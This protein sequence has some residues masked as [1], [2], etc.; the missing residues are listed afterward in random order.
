MAKEK[1]ITEE[2][3]NTVKKSGPG[4]LILGAAALL[5]AGGAGAGSYFLTPAPVEKSAD[6]SEQAY[7]VNNADGADKHL[8]KSPKRKTKSH[9]AKESKHSKA[10]EAPNLGG[11]IQ[12]AGDTAFFVLDPLVV[13]INPIGRSRHLKVVLAVETAPEEADAIRQ[14]ALHIR[15]AYNTYL[16]SVDASIFEDPAA[17]SRMRSQLLRRTRAIAPDAEIKNVLITEFILT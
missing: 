17:M 10:T 12:L 1:E 7:A 11:E 4:P 9:A 3:E 6:Q 2:D 14:R 16:R 15:D 5:S 13:S 8:K